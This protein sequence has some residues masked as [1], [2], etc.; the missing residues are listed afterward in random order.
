[1]LDLE[2]EKDSVIDFTF[3]P[4]PLIIIEMFFRKRLKE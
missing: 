2:I 1:M 4:C 3:I